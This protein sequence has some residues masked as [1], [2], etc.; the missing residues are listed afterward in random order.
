[1]PVLQTKPFRVPDGYSEDNLKR[2]FEATT[3]Q[4]KTKALVDMSNSPTRDNSMYMN[5]DP[6]YVKS[7]KK[8]RRMRNFAL[9]D[10]LPNSLKRDRSIDGMSNDATSVGSGHFNT[11]K[12]K[13]GRTN[14]K[15][16]N[17]HNSGSVINRLAS[18]SELPPM[19]D[20]SQQQLFMGGAQ[21]LSSL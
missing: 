10:Y 1:M 9:N 19:D 3:S 8:E 6:D 12:S 16:G 20:Q 18:L 21:A 2:G 17:R 4:H 7:V 15:G 11:M 14:L 13:M 5:L